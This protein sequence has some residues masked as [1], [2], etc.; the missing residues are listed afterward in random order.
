MRWM[1]R[2]YVRLC[3]KWGPRIDGRRVTFSAA[4]FLRAMDGKPWWRNRID[5]AALLIFGEHRH[6]RHHYRRETRSTTD[7]KGPRP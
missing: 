5:G 1:C 3:R 6:C 4:A 2:A 7:A